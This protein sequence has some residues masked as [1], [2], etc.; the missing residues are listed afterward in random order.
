MSIEEVS[1]VVV[2]YFPDDNLEE[3]LVAI[4]KQVSHVVVVDNT[5]SEVISRRVMSRVNFLQSNK[6]SLMSNN[7]NRGVAQAL[8]IGI[9]FSEKI[10]AKYLLTLD[11]DTDLPIG[12]V[13]GLLYS[14]KKNDHN[15]RIGII[16]PCYVDPKRGMRNISL[17]R[18]GRFGVSRK[19]LSPGS[20]LCPVFFAITS[21][22]LHKMSVFKD[23]GKF[24]EDFFIDY[25]DFEFCLRLWRNGFLVMADSDSEVNHSLGT[26]AVIKVWRYSI[27]TSTHSSVRRYYITRN[28]LRMYF[29]YAIYFPYVLLYDLMRMLSL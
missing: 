19:P 25:V 9:T 29:Q 14:L 27:N 15:G 13:E 10:G 23:V 12:F 11:Q 20:G 17:V 5:D 24:R 1:A 8:N 16:S 3:R 18:Q 2:T 7:T 6:I 28:R 22:S 26:A 21:A 4:S